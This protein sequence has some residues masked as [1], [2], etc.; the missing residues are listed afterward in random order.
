M[1]VDDKAAPVE[2]ATALEEA[3]SALIARGLTLSSAIKVFSAHHASDES[4]A[5]IAAARRMWGREGE[6]EIDD[7]SITSGSDDEGDYVLAWVWVNNADAGLA[8][9][10]DE[11][12][13]DFEHEDGDGCAIYVTGY[14]VRH[15]DSSTISVEDLEVG[16]T[17]RDPAADSETTWFRVTD[18]EVVDQDVHVASEPADDDE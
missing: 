6:I 10:D 2:P 17:Y 13:E 15:G 14:Q 3:L 1:N 7:H 12:E 11:D 16:D 5:Y 9:D 8:D 4:T 18:I